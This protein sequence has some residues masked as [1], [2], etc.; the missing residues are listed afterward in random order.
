MKDVTV[1]CDPDALVTAI[2]TVNGIGAARLLLAPYCD[3][4]YAT[5]N[6]PGDALPVITGDI[7][8]VG[9]PS[10]K[11]RRDPTA[12]G[13]FRVLEVA[14]GATLHVQRISILGGR[15]TGL[16][17]G[18]LNAGTV[19][20][21]RTTLAGNRAGNGGAFA[22]NAD[23]TATIFL[24]RLNANSTMGVGGGAIINSGTLTLSK[25]VLAGNSAPVNG[26][27][28]NTQA[29]GVSHL[30]NSTLDNNVSGSLGGGISNLGTTTL[31]RVLVTRNKG[32][33]GGG[34]ST[35]NTNV[36][37]QNSTIRDNIPDNCNPLNT[38]PGCVD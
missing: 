12:P 23:A 8:L 11:I 30:I 9:G 15:T 3:Y 22:N 37:I 27:G 36:V 18:I 29:T 34:I 31:D 14:S 26:G 1:A 17:G 16:G 13:L 2:R 24:S 33:A 19:V 4:N 21:D 5:A 7:T 20:L 38:I 10:T 35:G 32:S 6:D 25:S 28:L